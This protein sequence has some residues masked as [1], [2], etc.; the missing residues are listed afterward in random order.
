MIT[1]RC[2]LRLQPSAKVG[3]KADELGF[4]HVVSLEARPV[5]P[6]QATSSTFSLVSEEDENY[7]MVPCLVP[8]G[9]TALQRLQR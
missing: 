9:C 3:Q 6:H 2:Q 7:P 1:N 8:E 4:D 5:Y